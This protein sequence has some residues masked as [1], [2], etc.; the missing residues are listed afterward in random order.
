MNRYSARST[1]TS[2][3]RLWRPCRARSILQPTCTFA[4]LACAVWVQGHCI[5]LDTGNE[6][7]QPEAARVRL[8]GLHV[9]VTIT[10]SVARTAFLAIAHGIPECLFVPSRARSGM[11]RSSFWAH[12]GM[13]QGR[14]GTAGKILTGAHPQAV[15]HDEQDEDMLASRRHTR[16]LRSF[17]HFVAQHACAIAWPAVTATEPRVLATR[18]VHCLH[19]DA[20]AVG[21]ALTVL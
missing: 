2:R 8:V 4:T 21:A 13:K 20:P 14:D 18:A 7:C 19:V 5:A 9:Q 11:L 16:V 10:T 1:Q 3:R 6:C 17:P 15:L 12:R